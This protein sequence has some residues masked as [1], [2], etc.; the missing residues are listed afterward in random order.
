MKI[1][2]KSIRSTVQRFRYPGG[3][4]FLEG[5]VCPDISKDPVAGEYDTVQ[6]F[7]RCRVNVS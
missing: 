1:L 3:S 2:P 7:K 5:G 4:I 6:I